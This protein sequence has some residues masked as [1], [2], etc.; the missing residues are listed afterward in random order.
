[1]KRV[2]GRTVIDWSNYQ[3]SRPT[4]YDGGYNV[5]RFLMHT[6][7]AD[8]QLQP[9]TWQALHSVGS[10]DYEQELVRSYIAKL[11]AQRGV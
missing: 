3:V 7:D 8:G 6:L 4:S 10:T 9:I 1:M 5:A 11:D 2:F